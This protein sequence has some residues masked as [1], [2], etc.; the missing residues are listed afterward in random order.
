MSEIRTNRRSFIQATAGA[1]VVAAVGSKAKPSAAKEK[2]VSEGKPIVA[3]HEWGKLNG[4]N[5]SF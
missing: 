4:T 2:T 5:L 3:H 1:A